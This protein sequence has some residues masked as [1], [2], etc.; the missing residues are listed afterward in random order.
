[1]F[2][3]TALALAAGIGTGIWLDKPPAAPVRS[4]S[5]DPGALRLRLDYRLT[6]PALQGP[7]AIPRDR[8]Q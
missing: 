7:S 8:P 6:N 2:A 1:M 5:D 3:A 4:W